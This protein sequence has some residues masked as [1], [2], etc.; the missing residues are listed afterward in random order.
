MDAETEALLNRTR[1]DIIIE[2]L[3]TMPVGHAITLNKLA[4][5]L[6]S[7]M[8]HRVS[9]AGWYESIRDVFKGRYKV[10]TTGFKRT[11]DPN[12]N[13]IIYRIA[14]TVLISIFSYL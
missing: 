7:S 13:L 5:M 14:L 3:S 1:V 8:P 10:K 2:T 6:A 4:E 12:G 11:K 9:V